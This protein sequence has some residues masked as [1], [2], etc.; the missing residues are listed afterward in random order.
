MPT[1]FQALEESNSQGFAVDQESWKWKLRFS[2]VQGQGFWES[3]TLP[4]TQSSLG[5]LW[6]EIDTSEGNSTLLDQVYCFRKYYL[7]LLQNIYSTSGTRKK[8][9]DLQQNAGH[10]IWPQFSLWHYPSS[11]A[12]KH[13]SSCSDGLNPA[14]LLLH[15]LCIFSG[16]IQSFIRWTNF[17]EEFFKEP[18]N[19]NL[20]RNV[21]QAIF[22]MLHSSH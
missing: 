21:S 7:R 8:H 9:G 10:V 12:G 1:H 20:T 14:P 16:Q 17:S 4:L 22:V 13:L 18:D 19:R 2:C 6:R 15:Y 3:V 11:L 5:H